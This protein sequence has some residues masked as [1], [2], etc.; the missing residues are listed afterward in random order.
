MASVL[1]GPFVT[2]QMVDFQNGVSQQANKVN[3]ELFSFP[4]AT[5]RRR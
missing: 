3:D 2:S 4:A 5:I 1:S